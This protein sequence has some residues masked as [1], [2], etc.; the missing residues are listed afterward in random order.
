VTF[1]NVNTLPPSELWREDRQITLEDVQI[2]EQIY[3]QEGNVGIY[4]A[5]HPYDELYIVV[6]NLFLNVPGGIEMFYGNDAQDKVLE[7]AKKLG[8]DLEFNKVWI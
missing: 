6:Y 4:A 3:H 5:W 1:S 8:I 7:K 2:W